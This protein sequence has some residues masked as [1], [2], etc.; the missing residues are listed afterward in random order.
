MTNLEIKNVPYGV[1]ASLPLL[2]T[3]NPAAVHTEDVASDTAT[4][5]TLTG[6]QLIEIVAE[7]YGVYVRRTTATDTDACTSSNFHHYVPAGST[8]HYGLSSDAT[9]LSLIGKGGTAD[10]IIIEY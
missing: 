6:T 9:G 4:S 10:V 1:P 7:D 8:R 2:P 3:G 5:I